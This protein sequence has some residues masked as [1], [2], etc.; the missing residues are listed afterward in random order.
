MITIAVITA[1]GELHIHNV[2]LPN[3]TTDDIEKFVVN[4]YGNNQNWQVVHKIENHK[5]DKTFIFLTTDGETQDGTGFG[6]ENCQ[7]L[8]T[9]KGPDA[10]TAYNNMLSDRSWTGYFDTCFCY[11]LASD[12]MSCFDLCNEDDTVYHCDKCEK[13]IGLSVKENVLIVKKPKYQNFMVNNLHSVDY[14]LYFR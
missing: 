2:Y 10:L 12:N 3:Y 5:E 9:A 11:E 14:V 6:I 7:M 8:A 4:Q 13:A 1:I